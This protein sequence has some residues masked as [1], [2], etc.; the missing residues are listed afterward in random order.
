MMLNKKYANEAPST[1]DIMNDI[2]LDKHYH[3]TRTGQ[4]GAPPPPVL[5]KREP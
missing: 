5:E 1:S 3:S 4:E 2:R